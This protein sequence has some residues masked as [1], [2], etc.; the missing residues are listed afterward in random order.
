MS[1]APSVMS[2]RFVTVRRGSPAA[3]SGHI[4]CYCPLQA[5]AAAG[6]AQTV[7]NPCDINILK[8]YDIIL[9]LCDITSPQSVTPH[10]LPQVS[11]QL[12]EI[13]G[14]STSGMTHS[15]AVEQIRRGGNRIHLV[16]KKGNGYVPDYGEAGYSCSTQSSTL[17]Y[18]CELGQYEISTASIATAGWREDSDWRAESPWDQGKAPGP[19]LKP[20]PQRLTQVLTGSRLSGRE[21]VGGLSL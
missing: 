2:H 10:L 13:N 4:H 15:Q 7:L 16:L 17:W 9:N 1:A 11:D 6:F 3:R 18:C 19:W 14:E 12:V 20:S 5:A 21:L 8:L